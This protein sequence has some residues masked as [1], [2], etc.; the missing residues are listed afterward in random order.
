MLVLLYIDAFRI[1]F[2][3]VGTQ[4]HAIDRGAIGLADHDTG[5]LSLHRNRAGTFERRR[6]RHE[7]GER[8]DPSL[9]ARISRR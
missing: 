8:Y 5:L 3:R 7:R 6:F 9:R 2:R 4:D 1:R